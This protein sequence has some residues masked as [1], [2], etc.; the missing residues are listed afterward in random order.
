MLHYNWYTSQQETKKTVVMLHGFISDHSTFQG[1]IESLTKT[2]NLLLVDLPGHGDDTSPM[3][4][5]WDFEWIITQL[6]ELLSRYSEYD[7]YLHGYSMGAR[8]ALGYA[9]K[10]SEM[11]SGL[12]LESG[13]PGIQDEMARIERQQVDQARARVLQVA[14]IEVFVNDWERL[15]LF[16][17][18]QFLSA[19][20]QQRIRQ[21]RLSQRPERLAKALVDY[22]T[23]NMPNLWPRLA[24]IQ[25]PVQLIVGEWD[26]KFV[27]IAHKM[28]Q[29]FKY[30]DIQIVPE[31]G[32]TVHVE[33]YEK[34]DTIILAFILAN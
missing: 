4:V 5:L 22:G 17:S 26:E 34:F 12:V 21:M 28:A 9:T 20:E 6:H 8:V 33:E 24:D 25:C 14:N 31:V 16:Q 27:G 18:Q 3:T 1:H 7:L 30:A 23:G 2:V 29:Q 11:L 32:H 10:H 15:P 19:E 13:S